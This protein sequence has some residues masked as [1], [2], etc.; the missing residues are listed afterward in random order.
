MANDTTVQ[1]PE[2]NDVD[3]RGG[4]G[5][6]DAY[7]PESQGDSADAFF[8]AVQLAEAAVMV[9]VPQGEHVI[10]VNVTPGE[11][12]ELAS[13]FDADAALLAREADGNL[14]IKVGDVTVILVGYVDANA[15]A[16][17]VVQASDGKPLD[18]AT[19][20]AS[21]DP[22]LDIQT[23]AGPG[24][25]PAQGGQGAD[26]TGA[27]LSQL[28]GGDG[29]GGLN[30]VGKLDQ[31]ALQY[32]NIG[33]G[34]LQEVPLQD[35]GG[36]T[37][38]FSGLSELALRDPAFTGSFNSFADFKSA[39][40]SSWETSH[41]GGADFNGT[42]SN[43]TD[44]FATYLSKTSFVSP[45]GHSSAE[46]EPIFL[47]FAKDA[48]VGVTSNGSPLYIDYAG[49]DNNATVFVRRESDDAIVLVIHA[50]AAGDD[51]TNISTGGYVIDTY[52]INHL[53]HAQQGHDILSINLP[54]EIIHSGQEIP[55]E[56]S[57]TVDILDDTP[58][59][60]APADYYNQ[61]H[62]F[63]GGG[64][65]DS[66]HT[67]SL[68][69]GGGN[70]EL[71][72]DTIGRVDED[73]LYWGNHDQ[74]NAN[75]PDSD[76]KRGDETGGNAVCGHLNVDF[77]ADGPS[78]YDFCDWGEDGRG[79]LVNVTLNAVPPALALNT[80][81]EA[82]DIYPGVT[83]GGQPL[84]VLYSDAG[85]L[86]VGVQDQS[87]ELFPQAS[88]SGESEGG[89]PVFELWL[90]NDPNSDNFQ[91][92]EFI[93]YQGLDQKAASTAESSLLLDF[94]VLATD[95]DG[96]TISTDIKISVNDD[97]PTISMSYTSY[98]ENYEGQSGA[99]YSSTVGYVDEDWL[100]GGNRDDDT[101][102]KVL[103]DT[104]NGDTTG[105]NRVDG[106]VSVAYGGDGVG[107]L[108]A[109]TAKEGDTV[110]AK[111][112]N[113]TTAPLKTD[114]GHTVF[115]HIDTSGG[116][117]T[118]I[119]FTNDDNSKVFNGKES[120][121]VFTLSLNSWG[122]AF[123]FTLLEAVQHPISGKED[124]LLVSFGVSAADGDGDKV[125]GAINININ[126]DAPHAYNDSGYVYP[127]FP[128]RET[129]RGDGFDG[130]TSVS[131][132]SSG[133]GQ[134]VLLNDALGADRQS[135]VTQLVGVTTDAKNSDG[136]EVQGQFGILHMDKDGNWDYTADQSKL[137]GAGGNTAYVEDVFH[138]TVTDADGDKSTAD[139]TVNVS[140]FHCDVTFFSDTRAD[141][142]SLNDANTVTKIVTSDF[143]A[144]KAAHA[145][146]SGFALVDSDEGHKL[147]GTD[148]HDLLV[149]HGGDDRLFGGGNADDLY[150]GSGNDTLDGGTGH[151]LMSG[152]TGDDTFRNVDADDL[153][154]S[155]TFDG[156]HSIDGG[157]GTDTL[158][159]SHLSTFDSA[160]A[161]HV[162]N[163][164]VLDFTGGGATAVSL[165]YDAAYG[166]TQV[167]GLHT[168]TIKGDAGV[169]TVTLTPSSGNSWSQT[170]TDVVGADGGHYD[171]FEAGS[172]AAKVTVQVEH[173]VH[174]EAS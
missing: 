91:Q 133:G 95:G 33:A 123:T 164:E 114:D 46:G 16:P 36:G 69:G 172:G 63:E 13:P 89:C 55:Q 11:I 83:S 77:G 168:F 166:I 62:N 127:G 157:D 90:N 26:N 99:T 42:A 12:L 105:T 88:T 75:G 4:T 45:I 143:D 25:Q 23:A 57:T 171:V 153:D 96:D 7:F 158:D 27:I 137:S 61:E 68:S 119:G 9:S 79:E 8:G 1:V 135:F 117:T 53:D 93:L 70:T 139:L 39:L 130:V 107:S 56:G 138:Y 151:D 74:D 78:G 100:S 86:V 155:R 144:S 108:L 14:A 163:V 18:V 87:E 44:D 54:Y 37:T 129:A 169:D 146:G 52:L 148:A 5:A 40:Q 112:D 17:V 29:L 60:A 35:Q 126:D 49:G 98:N 101:S 59:I 125:S 73:W 132:G 145:E 85:H 15:Q 30:A 131:Y 32:H 82:G 170:G 110:L 161:S 167:G 94:P 128:S 97:A 147:V 106:Y 80:G 22:T 156:V 141:L 136:L 111:N 3:A 116:V 122:G 6:G 10:R 21:T 65:N 121:E 72:H 173:G 160:Q 28:E 50:H 64:G 142:A 174:V 67:S 150:G 84:V 109:F 43:N 124:N 20:L 2:S 140:T 48:F 118:L 159:L 19:L 154:G 71:V 38:G 76:S 162:E 115:L 47:N 41:E 66:L 165:N 134:N 120:T 104:G 152:G 103:A 31:T 24:G 81:L 92:F 58:V 102:V 51:T 34:I 113:G 149:G